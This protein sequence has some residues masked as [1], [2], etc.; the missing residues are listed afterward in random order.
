[1]ADEGNASTGATIT[2]NLI[3]VKEEP[4]EEEGDVRKNTIFTY[5][6][7]DMS[8]VDIVVHYDE[9]QVLLGDP[10]KISTLSELSLI[11]HQKDMEK[12][13]RDIIYNVEVTAG[14][15]NIASYELCER[16]YSSTRLR[17]GHLLPAEIVCV[18]V[19]C[20]LW[21]QREAG[22]ALS[23]LT[24]HLTDIPR[25]SDKR[26]VCGTVDIG[27]KTIA[28][29]KEI[30]ALHSCNIELFYPTFV[31]RHVESVLTKLTLLLARN[32][33]VK[34][35]DLSE[36]AEFAEMC[37][38]YGL[39][40]SIKRV[41]A[42][43]S[44]FVNREKF[45]VPFLFEL[46]KNC[47][48]HA[49]YFMRSFLNQYPNIHCVQQMFMDNQKELSPT[50]TALMLQTLAHLAKK[51][52]LRPQI[53]FCFKEGTVTV[54][55][56]DHDDGVA[57]N[58]MKWIHDRTPTVLGKKR[59]STVPFRTAVP[60]EAT[61]DPEDPEGRKLRITN[62]DAN[63]HTWKRMLLYKKPF[64]LALQKS[65]YS[66]NQYNDYIR[67]TRN[68]DG[69]D[70]LGVVIDGEEFINTLTHLIEIKVTHYNKAT[71]FTIK[72]DP[73]PEPVSE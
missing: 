50:V 42:D 62:F 5:V 49:G 16:L 22:K 11:V 34:Y 24:I 30:L 25:E 64:V 14:S 26:R 37:T 21:K 56:L 15:A 47:G 69:F 40:R 28:C 65:N 54:E 41:I 27:G 3:N 4:V 20:H 13:Q 46:A 7:E 68:A 6:L 36:Y 8:C 45:N 71:E 12:G 73:A 48:E 57:K 9:D 51:A 31:P 58:F 43:I 70:V 66:K 60:S 61:A 39:S 33:K 63:Y 19:S 53:D 18:P 52:Q 35:N 72:E 1:M 23:T 2:S 67:F 17:I 29:S 32:K 38:T 44:V 59:K 10:C 55:I